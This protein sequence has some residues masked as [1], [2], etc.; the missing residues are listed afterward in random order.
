MPI[1]LLFGSDGRTEATCCG[2]CR[3]T[4]TCASAVLTLSP[5][6]PGNTYLCWDSTANELEQMEEPPTQRRPTNWRCTAKNVVGGARWCGLNSSLWGAEG[7]SLCG[8]KWGSEF[9]KLGLWGKLQQIQFW[10]ILISV[11]AGEERWR[12]RKEI[13]CLEVLTAANVW[14]TSQQRLHAAKNL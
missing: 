11:S 8:R 5:V 9:L 12:R 14:I 13:L 2:L 7:K 4:T 3:T 1:F 10:R 6:A